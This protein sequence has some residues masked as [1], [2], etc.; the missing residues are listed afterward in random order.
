MP[1]EVSA[2]ESDES[3]LEFV[4]FE[5]DLR[6]ALFQER[7]HMRLGLEGDARCGVGARRTQRQS[8]TD[9]LELVVAPG[10]VGLRQPQRFEAELNGGLLRDARLARTGVYDQTSENRRRWGLAGTLQLAF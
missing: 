7:N 5:S 10:A 3:D 6:A 4:A 8:S 2:E 9:D 1:Q